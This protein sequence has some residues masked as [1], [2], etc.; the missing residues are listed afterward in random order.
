[1][2]PVVNFWGAVRL[3]WARH[4][5]IR[6]GL[7]VTADAREHDAAKIAFEQSMGLCEG[8][9]Q[10]GAFFK[11]AAIDIRLAQHLLGGFAALGAHRIK[12]KNN[13]GRSANRQFNVLLSL[14]HADR[15]ASQFPPRYVQKADSAISVCLTSLYCR[16][17][18]L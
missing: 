18:S 16:Y 6:F 12:F 14:S 5:L 13:S 11:F 8:I 7:G 1:M 9:I 4:F 10:F 17:W 3:N 15:I 2:V